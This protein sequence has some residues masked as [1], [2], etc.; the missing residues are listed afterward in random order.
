MTLQVAVFSGVSGAGKT[1]LIEKLVPLMK[2]SG[3]RVSVIKHSHHDLE[4]DQ[5]GKDTWRHRDAGAFEV[6]AASNR[7]LVLMRQFE[8]E[9]PLS[10]HQLLAEVS[11]VA[12]WILVEGFRDASLCKLELW[13]QSTG[14]HVLYPMD[15]FVVS[16][17]SDTPADLPE[18]T[19]LPVFHADDAS[20]V[21]EWMQ[22]NAHR[23]NYQFPED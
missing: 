17:V 6:V 4:L 23:F 11:P 12:D 16:V 8:V 2:A 10:I 19:G 5:P 13:R 21:W 9:T 1:T 7:Q 18:P 22:A 20:G 15:P 3:C 14:A